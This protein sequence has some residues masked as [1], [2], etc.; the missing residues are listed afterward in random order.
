LIHKNSSAPRGV[1]AEV[2]GEVC[3]MKGTLR[4][5]S[6]NLGIGTIASEKEVL[7]KITANSDSKFHLKLAMRKAGCM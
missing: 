3:G 5:L 2:I 1:T 7:E 4:G 6:Q